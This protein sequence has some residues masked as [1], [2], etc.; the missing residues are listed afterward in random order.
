MDKT[1]RILIVGIAA[2]ALVAGVG[3]VASL[4]AKSHVSD[5]VAQCQ[6]EN[7]RTPP[8]KSKD[9]WEDAPLICDPEIL[10][11][12]PGN[13]PS[14]GIQ[15]QIVD[16]QRQGERWLEQATVIAIGV[17]IL[18]AIPYTWYF[19]L[20]RVRELRDAIIGK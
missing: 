14:V 17:L 15:A 4:R 20:W 5:Y 6:A 12:R 9:G 16:T 11:E 10:L 2:A 18:S 7:A 1:I 3:Y 13:S 19:L 8:S